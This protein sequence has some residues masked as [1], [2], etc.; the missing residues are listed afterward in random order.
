[1]P[2][3]TMCLDKEC[4]RRRRCYRF[5][6]KESHLGQSYFIGSPR[7]GRECEYYQDK[8]HKKK[9]SMRAVILG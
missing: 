5:S 8:N 2:D 3:I 6:A 1:M 7:K 4:S 9:P